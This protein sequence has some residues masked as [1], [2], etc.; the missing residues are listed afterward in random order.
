MKTNILRVLGIALVFS[1]SMAHADDFVSEADGATASAQTPPADIFFDLEPKPEK[2]ELSFELVES[3]ADPSV[4][5]ICFHKY[6]Y[7]AGDK[8]QYI[9]CDCILK[10]C[11]DK[12]RPDPF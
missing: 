6:C 2:N 7:P 12:T 8:G 3:V 11:S 9:K 4:T 10:I 1:A 5:C